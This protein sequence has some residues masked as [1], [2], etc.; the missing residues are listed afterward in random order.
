MAV[1]GENMFIYAGQT[2]T[3]PVIAAA[4]SCS[5]SSKCDLNERASASEQNSKE[6]LAGRS[7]WDVSIDHLVS[8]GAP[9]EGLL[10]VRNTYTIS[11]VIGTTRKYGKAICVQADLSGAV[12]NLA[13]GVVK[14]KGTGP[15]MDPST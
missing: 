14:F 8:S 12:G 9:F 1:L 2:G 6:F 3:T 7:E 11:V 13:R 4:K 15:L 10:K 5:I